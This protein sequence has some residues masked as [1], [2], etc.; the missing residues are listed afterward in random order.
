MKLVIKNGFVV[1]SHADDQ[2]IEDKYPDCE[3]AS[4]P[5]GTP[6]RGEHGE[7]FPDPRPGLNPIDLAAHD[8]E[9]KIKQ[10]MRDLAIKDLK[11]S[12]DLPPDYKDK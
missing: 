12:G 5:D 9:L 4:V 6:W 1:A 11:D 8:N 3:I 10:K 2:H 7:Q